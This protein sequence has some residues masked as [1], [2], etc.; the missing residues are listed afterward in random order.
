MQRVT[1]LGATGS[2]GLSTLAVIRLHPDKFQLFALTARNNVALMR[3]AVREFAPAY[4][5]ME[6]AASAAELRALLPPNSPTEVLAGASALAEVASASEV[7]TVVAA[8]V[9]A[10]GLAP[11]LAAVNHGKRVLLANKESLVMAGRL[12]IDAVRANGACLL[13]VD[14]EHNAMFQCLPPVASGINTAQ[15]AELGVRKLI[16]TGSGGPFRTT[17]LPQLSAVTPEQACAHPNWAMGRKI[18]VD[19]ATMMNKGLE[20]IEA[21]WLFGADAQCLQ[22][23]IHPQSIIHSMVEYVDGSVLAQLGQPDMRTPIANCLGWPERLVTEVPSI[24]FWR[25]G[26]LEFAEPDFARFPLLQ[27]AMASQ[28]QGGTAPALLNAANEVAVAAFLAEHIAFTDIARVVAEVLENLPGGEPG[29]LAE[30]IQAD[31]EARQVAEA[32]I[33]RLRA[34]RSQ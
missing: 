12:F 13:P 18:S 1:V 31:A 7:D 10:A 19:S 9:G 25:L 21:C 27:L 32:Q 28:A 5:V 30:V 8:I 14:S 24:D 2:I 15:L 29:S 34:R 11:T 6:S 33:R 4:A 3:D 22:V 23:V 26:A 20:F 16:L 17:P